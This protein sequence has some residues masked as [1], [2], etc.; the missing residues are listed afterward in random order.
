MSSQAVYTWKIPF[1]SLS[2][3][4]TPLI[5]VYTN[6]TKGFTSLC[7]NGAHL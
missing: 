7:R 2:V 3:S 5:R 6:K 4:V 1:A